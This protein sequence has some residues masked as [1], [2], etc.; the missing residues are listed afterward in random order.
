MI[1]QMKNNIITPF[2]NE[3]DPLVSVYM[4]QGARSIELPGNKHFDFL[5]GIG[6]PAFRYLIVHY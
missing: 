4:E 2:V 1:T 5:D 6:Q 3:G